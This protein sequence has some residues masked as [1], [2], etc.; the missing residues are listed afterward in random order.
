MR[1]LALGLDDGLVAGV[2]LARHKTCMSIC[3]TVKLALVST[4]KTAMLEQG[5]IFQHH[6]YLMH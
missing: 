4:M 2:F 6:Q 3:A 1:R 5:C